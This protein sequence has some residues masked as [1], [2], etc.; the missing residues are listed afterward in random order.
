MW[1]LVLRAS[2]PCDAA[3]FSQHVPLYKTDKRFTFR[4]ADSHRDVMREEPGNDSLVRK[5]WTGEDT[6]T[7]PIHGE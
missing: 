1:N 5:R 2:H 4:Y 3:R 7:S 6:A